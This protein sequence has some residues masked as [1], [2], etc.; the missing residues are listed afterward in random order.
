[1]SY[2]KPARSAVVPIVILLLVLGMT[3]G[4]VWHHH[5]DSSDAACPICHLVIV[6]LA[7]GIYV[8]WVPAPIATVSE[9]TYVG[10]VARSVPRLPARA[11]PTA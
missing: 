2:Q 9:V 10:P 5:V 4:M 8:G 1:M 3:F 11:P 6:P 7:T